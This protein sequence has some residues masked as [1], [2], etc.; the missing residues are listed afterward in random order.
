MAVAA[1]GSAFSLA[2]TAPHAVRDLQPERKVEAFL[3]NRAAGA[4]GFRIPHRF[5]PGRKEVDGAGV[6]RTFGELLPRGREIG[7][8]HDGLDE[9]GIVAQSHPPDS[10]PRGL[11]ERRGQGCAFPVDNPTGNPQWPGPG[12]T[13]SPPACTGV[14]SP[15]HIPHFVHSHL[16]TGPG[17]LLSRSRISVGSLAPRPA[18][19]RPRPSPHPHP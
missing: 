7:F 19:H 18:G 17:I 4:H 11:C 12:S 6:V 1:Q 9:I 8:A 10:R 13:P 15:P 5:A 3:T 2:E 16:S 14:Q